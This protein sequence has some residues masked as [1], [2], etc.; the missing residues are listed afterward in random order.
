MRTTKDTGL[1]HLPSKAWAVNNA[2]CLAITIAVDLL[3]WLRLLG[4]DNLSALSKA[5]PKT[6]R[7]RLLTIP[8]RLV[9]GQRLRTLRLPRHWPWSAALVAIIDKIRRIP[10]PTPQPG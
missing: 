3:A 8:G 7:Y 5:E 2:W 6:L 9:R 10:L 1:G 4:C